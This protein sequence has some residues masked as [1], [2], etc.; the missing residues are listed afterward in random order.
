MDDTQ[1]PKSFPQ[2]Q[3]SPKKEASRPEPEGFFRSLMNWKQLA[4]A[5][6][7]RFGHFRLPF[8]RAPFHFGGR[9]VL[10]ML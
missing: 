7:G 6:G 9:N 8:F 2:L 1:V 10:Y 4:F 3:I 5:R